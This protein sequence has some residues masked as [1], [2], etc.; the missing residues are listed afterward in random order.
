VRLEAGTT[1]GRF[2]IVAPLAAGGMGEVYR[3]RDRQL[4]RDLAIKVLPAHATTSAA[5]VER[6]VHEALSASALNHPNI[7][8][9]YDVGEADVGRY[10]AMEL[11]RGRTFATLLGTSPSAESVAH[12]GAQAARALAVAHAAGIV[13]RDVK[14]DNLMVRDDGYV[15]VLD[16]G[17]ARLGPDALSQTA[18]RADPTMSGMVLGTVGYMSPEQA[19]GDHVDSPTDVFSL[20]VVLYELLTSRHPFAADTDMVMLATMLT[21]EAR[22]A[23][24]IASGIPEQFDALLLEMLD[25]DPEQRPT[26]RDVDDALSR[27]ATRQ[28]VAAMPE[29]EPIVGDETEHRVSV[30]RE[31]ERAELREAFEAVRAGRSF[32]ACVSGEPGLGKTTL[33]EDFLGDIA[34]ARLPYTVAKGRCSERLAGTEAY[35]PLLDALDT[36]LRADAAARQAMRVLA[37]SW[38]AQIVGESVDTG[39]GRRATPA[40][41]QERMK[42]ELAAFFQE[43]CR[44]RPLI[45]FLDDVHW[46][47]ASTVDVLAYVLAR[48]E[49]A[50]LLV[51][52]T[53]RPSELQLS[54][55]PFLSLLL[56]R[57]ARRQ[58]RN[59]ELSFLGRDD[60]SL[61]LDARFPGHR[62]PISFVELIHRKTEG[63]PLFIVNLLSYLQE[64]GVVREEGG[65]WRVGGSIPDLAREIPES[66]RSMV[67]RK[68]DQ[69]SVE[70]RELLAASAVQGAEFDSATVAAALSREAAE[71][72]SR[73]Q[74]LDRVHEL[75]HQSEELELP[76]GS[77]SVRYR[78]VHIFYHD[79]LY[80]SLSPSRRV[81][82]SG[83]VAEAVLH[84]HRPQLAPVAAQLGFLFE[85]ARDYAKAGEYFQIA[86]TH[87][88]SIFAHHEA[89]ALARR[90]MAML[91]R[92]P[93]SGE[94]LARELASQITV[95]FST[96]T[97]FGYAMPDVVTALDRARQLA[98]QL[99]E[100]PQ[101]APALWG[102]WAYYCTR[103]QLQ[104]AKLI[105]ERLLR[106][107]TTANDPLLLVNGHVALGIALQFLGHLEESHSQFGRAVAAYDPSRRRDYLRLFRWDSGVLARSRMIRTAWVLG[108]ADEA[109]EHKQAVLELARETGDP[110][111]LALALVF[112]VTGDQLLGKPE[113]ALAHAKLGIAICDEHGIAQERAW[114]ATYLGWAVA[115]TQ[116]GDEGIRLMQA[117]IATL[118]AMHAEITLPFY[119]GVLAETQAKH[120]HRIDALQSIREG[121]AVSSRTQDVGYDAYLLRLRG[122]LEVVTDAKTAESSFRTAIAVARAQG[123]RAYELLARSALAKLSA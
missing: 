106:I 30:G 57:Q 63:S 114:L 36:L 50:R 94:R 28:A 113:D 26:A 100:H 23:S 45:L 51:V 119:L 21:Q 87:A 81:T 112:V 13:H 71:I 111:T 67:D 69:L 41:S 91:E 59:V 108:R 27:L 3:A 115:E 55:H 78:F 47:D 37:P 68:I 107:A 70:D 38:N 95:G 18:D 123:A 85:T 84:A 32:L 73:F 61:L 4:G 60:V 118:R 62:F 101:L 110:R 75:I 92:L 117:S 120:G 109:I 1:L 77:L 83:R 82:L 24:R 15:K 42:R 48:L 99:G 103:P 80:A 35:L 72:E 44:L 90:S 40:G 54:K 19:C 6:F 86:A 97:G 58:S 65:A 10:I 88:A 9:I 12:L 122:E 5:A 104:D 39:G 2:D 31:S 105:A 22:P 116:D 66:V 29:P 93:L 89:I 64:R 74:A 96:A 49:S 46:A 20:G 121:L 7:I 34:G 33:V 11:V 56:E 17:I 102:L 98:E 14:P 25:K 76:N 53:Y 43:V 52:V 16:F 8:T 79:A